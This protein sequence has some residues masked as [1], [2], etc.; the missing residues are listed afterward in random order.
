MYVYNV[1]TWIIIVIVKWPVR[2]CWP[3]PDERCD[4]QEI[5]M[6]QRPVIKNQTRGFAPCRHQP[7]GKPPPQ[8]STTP[9]IPD[10]LQDQGSWS[11]RGE[12]RQVV[13]VILNSLGLNV[14]I[15]KNTAVTKTIWK[16][17]SGAF[18]HGL[19]MEIVFAMRDYGFV[20]FF[21]AH[22]TVTCEVLLC[23]YVCAFHKRRE[24]WESESAVVCYGVRTGSGRTHHQPL[25]SLAAGSP[26]PCLT[27]PY[28]PLHPHSLRS[29]GPG[30]R[31][32]STLHEVYS[33]PGRISQHFLTSSC[34]AGCAIWDPSLGVA[35]Q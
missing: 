24:W 2:A 29:L 6:E 35:S 13:V 28:R 30:L 1:H 20:L 21:F 8:R 17:W 12:K 23:E 31:F 18:R 15:L 16:E 33:G 4:I 22:L 34:S 14:K 11:P 26:S 27:S 25:G 19:E 10:I 7:R 5:L 9:W 32:P 3:R